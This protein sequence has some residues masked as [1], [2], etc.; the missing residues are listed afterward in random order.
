MFL[1]TAAPLLSH[2]SKASNKITFENEKLITN[3]QQMR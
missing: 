1:K 2:K 3:N